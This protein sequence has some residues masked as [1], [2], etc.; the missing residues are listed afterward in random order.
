[1]GLPGWFRRWRDDRRR[2]RAARELDGRALREFVYLDEVSVFSLMSSRR[3]SVATEFTST[4][5]NSLASD[6]SGTTGASIGVAKGEIRSRLQS[7]QTQGTQ[8]LRKATVQATFRELYSNLEEGLLLRPKTSTPP[9]E[10]GSAKDLQAALAMAAEEGWATR[11]EDLK[12]GQLLEVEVELEAE[13]IFRV[14][15]LVETFLNLF[16]EVPDAL[17]PTLRQQISQ[18]RWVNGLFN[19]VLAGLVPIRG[20]V[21]E[22]VAVEV[23]GESW[24]VH[25][26]VQEDLAQT[27]DVNT[28]PLA[29]VAVAEA[30]LFWKDLRRVLFSGSRYSLLCRIGRDGLHDR[31]TP[32]KLVDVFRDFVPM[33]ADQI[34]A[35]GPNLISAMN[36]GTAASEEESSNRVKMQQ[37]LAVYGEDLAT[38]VGGQW[39]TGLIDESVLPIDSSRAWDTVEEQRLAFAALTERLRG[40]YGVELDAEALAAARHDALLRVGLVPLVAP[41]ASLSVVPAAPPAAIPPSRV[42]DTEVIAIYW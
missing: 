4:Q 37:A 34:D 36:V 40:T 19:R 1:M 3:G 26:T 6:L 8:V 38:R 12:R 41:P 35:A 27:W 23:G 11:S 20:K 18:A 42:L 16:Q 2:K 24:V 25:R 22:Y 29:V 5:S 13:S 31:W 30:S 21:V 39:D 7:T 10:L 33:V 9:Q 15:A 14:G 17:G 32:V 28:Y